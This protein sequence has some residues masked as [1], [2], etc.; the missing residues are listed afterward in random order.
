MLKDLVIQVPIVNLLICIAL[1]TGLIVMA[2]LKFSVLVFY[3]SA[4]HLVFFANRARIEALSDT[5]TLYMGSF[6]ISGIGMVALL[7][8]MF[9][10]DID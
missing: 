3:L 6:I 1:M 9:M 8:W 4:F 2:R 10:S 7:I 5:E